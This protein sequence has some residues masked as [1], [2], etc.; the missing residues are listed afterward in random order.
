[1]TVRSSWY[2][3]LLCSQTCYG[4]I[5]ESTCSYVRFPKGN[6]ACK[7]CVVSGACTSGLSLRPQPARLLQLFW[8]PIA[9]EGKLIVPSLGRERNSVHNIQSFKTG[10]PV[11][12]AE[13]MSLHRQFIFQSIWSTGSWYIYSNLSMLERVAA[14]IRWKINPSLWQFSFSR[15]AMQLDA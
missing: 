13:K 15:L 11:S 8:L 2:S 14:L 4:A 12:R 5:V 7:V 9:T 3:T 6:Q 10:L 1:M